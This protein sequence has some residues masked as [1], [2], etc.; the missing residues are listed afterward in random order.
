M[1]NLER[2][3]IQFFPTESTKRIC[4]LPAKTMI[5]MESGFLNIGTERQSLSATF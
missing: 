1:L 2:N 5:L 4:C 3:I